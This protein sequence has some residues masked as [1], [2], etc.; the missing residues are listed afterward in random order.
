MTHDKTQVQEELLVF[1]RFVPVSRLS[2]LPHT[3]CHGD[4]KTD[5]PDIICQDAGGAIFMFEL[6]ELASEQMKRNWSHIQHSYDDS[7]VLSP[8]EVET[9][10]CRFS[11]L[12]FLVELPHDR[13]RQA[14]REICRY[15]ISQK[16]E[17]LLPNRHA[18]RVLRYDCVSEL[19]GLKGQ[20]TISRLSTGLTGPLWKV[21]NVTSFG[22]GIKEALQRK[23]NNRYRY[24]CGAVSPQLLLYYEWDP[25]YKPGFGWECQPERWRS[26]W[27][28]HFTDVWIFDDPSEHILSHYVSKSMQRSSET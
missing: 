12:H 20:I 26:L 28:S 2:I 7:G 17:E 6:S 10:R 13:T 9:F 3:T 27:E 19:R 1:N 16:P 22:D 4:E 24:R 15:L 23:A 8:T 11:G 5:E 21:S 14:L 25:S 18:S